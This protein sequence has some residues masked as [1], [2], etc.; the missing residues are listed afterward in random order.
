VAHLNTSRRLN[1]DR[2]IGDWGIGDWGIGDWGI[3]DWGIGDWG[4][5]DWGSGDWGIALV[6][7]TEFSGVEDTPVDIFN[8]RDAAF[9]F[10]RH[11][12]QKMRCFASRWTA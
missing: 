10:S 12:R 7:P 11:S 8:R 5:G 9:Q 1:G 2:C 3:G 4:I 6:I